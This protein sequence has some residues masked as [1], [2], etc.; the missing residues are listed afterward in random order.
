MRGDT[1]GNCEH[2]TVLG[3]EVW[4]GAP[5]ILRTALTLVEDQR[6]D[7]APVAPIEPP[8]C[9]P[10]WNAV[11]YTAGAADVAP[12]APV[13]VTGCRY[14]LDPPDPGTITQSADG[15]L[16][17]QAIVED[18]AT[19]VRLIAEGSRVDPC[20]GVAYD[21]E[22]TQDVLLVRDS[23]GDVQ[24]VSTTSCWANQLTGVRRY[25]GSGLAQ[26]VAEVLD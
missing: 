5:G 3:G 8:A 11:S 22:R 21:L 13:A 9:P 25:P 12:G 19:L 17:Q 4:S 15:V 7:T 10:R 16:Q 2:V 14:L 24:A 18:P 20:G 23:H 26:A 6:A 1:A